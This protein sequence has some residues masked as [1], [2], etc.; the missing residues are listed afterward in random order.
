[1]L[2]R[3]LSMGDAAQIV[4]GDRHQYLSTGMGKHSYQIAFRPVSMKEYGSSRKKPPTPLHKKPSHVKSCTCPPCQKYRNRPR[5]E[6]ARVT[7]HASIRLVQSVLEASSIYYTKNAKLCN[8][9]WTSKI[10]KNSIFQVYVCLSI[11][12][13][14]IADCPT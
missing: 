10:Q 6:V 2:K 14:A 8:V 9:L 7:Y 13:R 3:F 12:Q 4:H 11:H 1:M 5:K